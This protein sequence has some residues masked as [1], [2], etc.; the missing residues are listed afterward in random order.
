[1]VAGPPECRVVVVVLMSRRKCVVAEAGVVMFGSTSTKKLLRATPGVYL[2]PTALP[3]PDW[4]EMSRV[5]RLCLHYEDTRDHRLPT[6]TS[7]LYDYVVSRLRGTCRVSIRCGMYMFV[8]SLR[9]R[10]CVP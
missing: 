2:E 10:P 9:E 6:S 5:S 7:R 8:R 1:V 3:R 4:L